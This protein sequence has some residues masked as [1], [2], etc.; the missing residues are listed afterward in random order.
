MLLFRRTCSVVLMLASL[1]AWADAD[2]ASLAVTRFA[3]T[4][5]AVAALGLALS[6]AMAPRREAAPARA[7]RID[8]S[9]LG[10]QLSLSLFDD[11]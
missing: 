8:R 7:E 10:Q 4:V 9:P 2:T 11:D 6:H 1:L 3:L 5:A